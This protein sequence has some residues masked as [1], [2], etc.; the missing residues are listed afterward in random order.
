MSFQDTVLLLGTRK[1]LFTLKNGNH[2]WEV[3]RHDFAGQPVAYATLDPR[4]R[5][6]WAS[7]DHGHW[8][9]KL[10]RSS[11]GGRSWVEVTAP[12]YP[13]GAEVRDGVPATL[14]YLWYVAPGGADQPNRM[15]IGTEPGGLFQSDDGGDTF[16][17]VESLWNHPSRGGTEE[18]PRPGRWFGGGRDEAGIHSIIVDPRDSNRVL[19]GVSCAG[20]FETTDGGVTWTPRN[21]G[22]SADYLPD[23]NVDVGHDPHYLAYSPSNPDVLWQQNHCGI[24]RSADGGMNWEKISQE[25]GPA[26]FGFAIATHPD[27]PEIAWVVPADSDGKRMAPNGSVSVCRTEDGGRSWKNLTDGLP[28]KNGHDVT[29]R[30][31]LDTQY[32]RIVFG[33]TTGNVYASEDGGD[34]WYTVGNNFPPVYSVRFA[35]MG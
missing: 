20:V 33:T 11:D 31:A 28:Q 10:H 30:H 35:E 13:E 21:R 26:H 34:Q 16:T 2:G 19:I 9:Q 4:T 23:P 32:D 1:G 22:L 5:T 12:K 15:Y 17:L 6:L 29:F 8:G 14:R 18:L 25:G 24:F 3:D 7:I 27:D